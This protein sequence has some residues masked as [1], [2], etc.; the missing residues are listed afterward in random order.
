MN[1]LYE[2]LGLEPTDYGSV[3]GWATTDNDEF[4]IEFNHRKVT[5]DDGLECYIL[6]M[7][8]EPRYDFLEYE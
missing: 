1:E 4:W 5:M 7:S 2:F 6:E 3:I 8:F